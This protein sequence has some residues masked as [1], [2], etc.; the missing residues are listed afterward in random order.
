MA[1]IPASAAVGRY[2]RRSVKNTITGNIVLNAESVLNAKG[3]GKLAPGNSPGGLTATGRTTVN[4]GSI[5]S[6][7]IDT[8]VGGGVRGTEF[9]GLNT[10]SVSG[11]GAVFQIVTTDSQRFGGNYWTTNHNW[12]PEG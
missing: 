12:N 11:I 10:T 5:F 8:D 1:T 4:P 9:A 3:G 7:A 2:A 6:W